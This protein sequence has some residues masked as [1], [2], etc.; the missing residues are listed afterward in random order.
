MSGKNF[1]EFGKLF[2]DCF[3]LLAVVRLTLSSQKL[4]KLVLFFMCC[5]RDVIILRPRIDTVL[6]KI[7]FCKPVYFRRVVAFSGVGNFYERVVSDSFEFLK[8]L[9]TSCMTSFITLSKG[10]IQNRIDC[11][12]LFMC[13]FKTLKMDANLNSDFVWV[14]WVDLYLVM[15]FMVLARTGNDDIA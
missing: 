1:A 9:N 14:L 3:R 2:I 5:S 4:I 15:V 11:K 8:R 7:F 10:V 12:T 13:F 6:F